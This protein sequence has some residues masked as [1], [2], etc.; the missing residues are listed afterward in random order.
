MTQPP[1][2]VNRQLIAL[3]GGL[4][5]FLSAVEY[6][7]PK[8]LPF[9][10]LGLANFPLLL[11]LDLLP[12]SSFVLLL[13]LKVI[14]QALISGSLF[15]YVF[16]FSLAGT[17]LSALLMYVLRKATG[18]KWMSLTGISAAGAMAFNGVQL[19]LAWYLVF[20]ESVRYA[21]APIL[22]LGIVTGTLLGILSEYFT[23][24][25]LWYANMSSV[26][27]THAKTQRREERK[28]KD[29]TSKNYYSPETCRQHEN[30]SNNN[31]VALRL[32]VINLKTGL[33]KKFELHRKARQAFCRKHFGSGHLAITGLCMIPAL[34]FNPDT[35]ARL[36]QFLFFFFLAWLSGKKNN[37]FLTVLIML[38]IVFFNL[39]LPYGELLLN[40]GPLAITQ[41]ALLAGLR[42]AVT[43]EG[44]FM[45]SRCCVRE[46]LA[47]PGAFGEII[48]ES[49]RVFSRLSESPL[50]G[51]K[52]L[53]RQNWVNHLDGIL[54][55]LQRAPG[56]NKTPGEN[57][58]NQKSPA[59]KIVLVAVV[60][61]AWLPLLQ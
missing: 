28:G 14:G 48:G 19:V 59:A 41:G 47:L 57:G 60:I 45:L 52:G 22:A 39:L 4:C 16:L 25:S 55:A 51:K 32:C 49:F 54:L 40:I 18:K 46:D 21:A 43:L 9:I 20:G 27:E 1:G 7:I 6:L 42:R 10:R 29:K 8:P 24:H 34:L 13:A 37:L 17:G 2:K 38:G 56:E 26:K 53:W 35:K 23:K 15:S 30:V 50:A 5:F 11:A 31:L 12:F 33:L 58:L 3:F 61:L 44:L 36:I